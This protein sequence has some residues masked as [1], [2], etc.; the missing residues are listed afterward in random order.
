VEKIRPT[1]GGVDPKPL[2]LWLTVQLMA[3][4]FAPEHIAGAQLLCL[5]LLFAWLLPN[6]ATTVSIVLTGWACHSLGAVPLVVSVAVALCIVAAGEL[7]RLRIG[8][9]GAAGGLLTVG[10]LLLSYLRAEFF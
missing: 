5:G 3:L 2:A 7:N 10:A 1:A 4:R 8:W 6:R 9:L